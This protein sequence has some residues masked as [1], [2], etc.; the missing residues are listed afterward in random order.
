MLHPL[1]AGFPG[2]V[3][4]AVILVVFLILVV[5]SL[6]VAYWVARDAGR[7]GSDHRLA[8]GVMTF[9]SGFANLIGLA[10]FVVFYFFVRDDV[11]E[12]GTE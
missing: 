1:Q 10:V 3:E 5:L 7:R 8:W 11:G 2:A 6:A 4:L 12:V 9:L